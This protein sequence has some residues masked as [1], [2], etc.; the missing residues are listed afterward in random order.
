[1][2]RSV[3]ITT[4]I[5]TVE[6]MADF[7]GVSKSDRRFVERLFRAG[8]RRGA[9]APVKKRQAP[10]AENGIKTTGFPG[11]TSGRARKTA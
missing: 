7:Y 10:A 2:A 4:P 8:G 3:I 6:E 9:V 1:M 11:K 5:P